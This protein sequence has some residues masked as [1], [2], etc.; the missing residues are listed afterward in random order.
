VRRSLAAAA[1]ISVLGCGSPPSPGPEVVARAGDRD[2]GATTRIEDVVREDVR[3]AVSI[4]EG[5]VRGEDP[6]AAAWAAVYALRLGVGCDRDAAGAALLGGTGD[7]DPILRALCWRWL[8]TG[9]L[10]EAPDEPPAP[11]DPATAA[12]A[13]LAHLRLGDLPAALAPCLGLPGGTPGD[14]SPAP[15]DLV[16]ALTS[17]AAPYDDG[18][19]ALAI[20][21]A[22]ARRER[23]VE[24]DPGGE[25]RW[26]AERLRDELARAVLGS[27]EVEVDRIEGCPP[28]R[29]PRFS[30]LASLLET[31]LLERPASTLRAAVLRAEGSLRVG[32][33]RALAAV[34]VDPAAGDMGAAAAAM[35]ADDLWVRVE[36][37]RTYL[38]LAARATS[39][40]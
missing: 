2:A 24:V 35:R 29:D 4:L 10:L 20:A 23:W 5:A 8:A 40:D 3:L 16:G 6:T 26:A 33:L 13:A 1:L 37:A 12:L 39:D 19:L 38:L 17:R 21:F 11:I 36:A 7:E 31:P 30:D 22:A 28:C 9:L 18:P 14:P 27:D 15:G 32:A 34:A 25:P